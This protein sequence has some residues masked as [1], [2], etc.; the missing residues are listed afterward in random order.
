MAD[1]QRSASL[2]EISLDQAER[3]LDTQPRTP[4]HN[5]HRPHPVAVAAFGRLAH[6][7]HD[8]L[9]GGRIGGGSSGPC[10]GEHVRRGSRE[11]W[12]ASDADRQ[13]RAGQMRSW[14]SSSHRR[15]DQAR[16]C[17]STQTRHTAPV[18][19][20]YRFAL[21]VRKRWARRPGACASSA[22]LATRV[23]AESAPFMGKRLSRAATSSLAAW[24]GQGPWLN[25]C[26]SCRHLVPCGGTLVRIR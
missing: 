13:H 24:S 8:L 25:G 16:C 2:V 18:R 21:V 26:W 15:M 12:Q 17:T 19:C 20:E 4:E 11:A 22:A 7:C 9:D 14:D 1:E 23:P 10:C 5:D 3:L 6:H